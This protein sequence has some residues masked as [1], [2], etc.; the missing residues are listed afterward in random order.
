MATAVLPGFIGSVGLG[1]MALGLIEGIADF[2][3]SL[4]KL[5]GGVLG[6]YVQRKKPWT[7]AGYIVTSLCTSAIGL[8]S[9][10]WQMV[11]LRTVAWSSRGF[12]SPL[13]GFLLSDAVAKTHYGRGFGLERAGDMLGAVAGPLF[14]AAMV[15]IGVPFQS[16][17]FLGLLPGLLAAAAIVFL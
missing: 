3:V 13:R 8:T 4:S 1:P 12:R 11:T 5:G 9:A 16:I 6:H 2:L 7:A 15:G 17:I 10:L 14:A